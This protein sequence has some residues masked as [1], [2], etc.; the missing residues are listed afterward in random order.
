MANETV[1]ARQEVGWL[2]N[3]GW[4]REVSSYF[5]LSVE[6]LLQTA[7]VYTTDDNDLI[8]KNALGNPNITILFYNS[9]SA[10]H[11]YIYNYIIA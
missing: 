2:L 11:I 1:D 10:V 9:L 4:G 5:V 3:A 6:V 8:Q 7:L